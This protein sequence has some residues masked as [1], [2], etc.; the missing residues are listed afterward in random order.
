MSAPSLRG[1]EGGAAQWS[2]TLLPLSQCLRLQ[3][4]NQRAL[5]APHLKRCMLADDGAPPCCPAPGI[6]SSIQPGTLV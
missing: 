5:L 4:A 1:Q 3:R 6:S 2:P